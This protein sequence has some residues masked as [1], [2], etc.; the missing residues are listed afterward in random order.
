MRT[1]W[2]YRMFLSCVSP[3]PG[4]AKNSGSSTIA[5]N[6]FTLEVNRT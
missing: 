5:S 1:A 6:D 4:V 3:Y 2:L